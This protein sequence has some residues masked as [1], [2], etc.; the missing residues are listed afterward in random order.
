MKIDHTEF[1]IEHQIIGKLLL[2]GTKEK[3]LDVICELDENLFT[4][5][6]NKK[7]IRAISKLL[8]EGKNPDQVSLAYAL[9]GDIPVIEIAKLTVDIYSNA[10]LERDVC[11][12]K[13]LKYKKDLIEIVDKYYK[14]IK[15][16][17]YFDDIDELKNNLIADLS[18]LNIM[19]KSE[20]IKISNYTEK[21]KEQLGSGNKIEGYSWGISDLDIWTSGIVVP[22]VYVLGGLKKSGKTRFVIYVLTKLHDA[23][24]PSAFLSMEM[25]A[26]EITKLL[27]ASFTGMNDLRFRSGSFMSKDERYQF[28]N[29]QIN[30]MMFG[31]EC[32]SGLNISQVTSRI[33]RYSKM[34]YK[35]IFIDYLQR[36]LH[37]KNNLVND[38]ESSSIQIADA[39]R[40]NNVAIILL[41]QLNASAEN[42]NEPPNMG[43]L[44]GSGGIGEAPDSILLFDNLYRRTKKEL[45]KGIVDIYLEQRYSDSGRLSIWADLGS[46]RFN[47]LK[48]D[49]NGL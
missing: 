2:D 24:I 28:E 27:H 7:I 14:E 39:A 19:E 38:L 23:N 25:P 8:L 12:L 36:I 29:N 21:I 5:E 18:G 43:S 45:E 17:T 41:S 22:R 3:K 16:G 46:C 9:Q 30:E 1:D 15:I 42:P 37:D 44:K 13:E 47:N 4:N 35:V 6:K 32:K 20:F 31:I 11:F 49:Q 34:G 10:T 33:K 40:Q 26:Y 48:K